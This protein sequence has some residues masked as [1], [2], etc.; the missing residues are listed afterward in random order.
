MGVI[1]LQ[2]SHKVDATP[3][4]YIAPDGS[5]H[6]RAEE[7]SYPEEIARAQQIHTLV[8]EHR[9]HFGESNFVALGQRFREVPQ[10]VTDWHRTWRDVTHEI[11]A[12]VAFLDCHV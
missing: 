3:Y 6:Q 5:W 9:E 8:L 11:L 12:L 7:G 10:A 2:Q 1:E 4:A